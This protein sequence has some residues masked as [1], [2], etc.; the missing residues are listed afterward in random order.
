MTTMYVVRSGGSWDNPNI[1]FVTS[2]ETVA[3]QVCLFR[4]EKDENRQKENS[5]RWATNR[6]R[7]YLLQKAVV[8]SDNAKSSVSE[9]EYK[10]MVEELERSRESWES[11]QQ[12]ADNWKPHTFYEWFYEKV[13]VIESFDEAFK[14]ENVQ[15]EYG[16]HPVDQKI[17]V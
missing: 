15:N 17:Y 3:R 10:E 5:E 7:V 12:A 16:S 1:E 2:N 4:K 8:E 11:A 13:E 14:L 9:D 6:K